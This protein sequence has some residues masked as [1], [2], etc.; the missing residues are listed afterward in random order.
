MRAATG[1]NMKSKD[2]TVPKAIDH[3]TLETVS[4]AADQAGGWSWLGDAWKGARAGQS[5]LTGAA[6]QGRRW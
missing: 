3:V 5:W 1:S 2:V 6:A 4:G